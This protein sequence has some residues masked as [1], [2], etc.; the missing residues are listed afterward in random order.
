M[1][2]DEAPRRWG[3]VPRRLAVMGTV[4]VMAIGSVVGTGV[5]AD[6]SNPSS[7]SSGVHLLGI[8]VPDLAGIVFGSKPAFQAPADAVNGCIK[9]KPP[10][11]DGDE[12]DEP[13]SCPPSHHSH[14]SHNS[15]HSH[16]HHHSA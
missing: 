7:A 10:Y 3:R 6:A 13:H 4:A 12:D 8:H 15:P 9:H 5:A 16:H 2:N 14:H 11:N 1:E